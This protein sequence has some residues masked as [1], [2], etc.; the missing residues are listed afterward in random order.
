MPLKNKIYKKTLL[1]VL[2]ITGLFSRFNINPPTK[3]CSL[4]NTLQVSTG[5]LHTRL[6]V[7]DKEIQREYQQLETN[8]ERQLGL[9]AYYCSEEIEEIKEEVESATLNCNKFLQ[10][11]Y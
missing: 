5:V 11:Q 1:I 8:F 3:W 10:P 6:S 2:S 9:T 7:V 4:I